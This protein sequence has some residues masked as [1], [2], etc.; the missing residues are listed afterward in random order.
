LSCQ[1]SRGLCLLATRAITTATARIRGQADDIAAAVR[2]ESDQDPID[3]PNGARPRAGARM[4]RLIVLCPRYCGFS[5]QRLV[6]H[7]RSTRRRECGRNPR[8]IEASGG[9]PR[10]LTAASIAPHWAEP[11]SWDA[12]ILCC[13]ELTQN[14]FAQLVGPG[15]TAATSFSADAGE[16][17]GGAFDGRLDFSVTGDRGSLTISPALTLRMI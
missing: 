15:W 3:E 11:L 13:V 16:F 17:A 14:F 4:R 1:P 8:N 7:R 12:H 9:A 2:T 5:G 10:G 6:R